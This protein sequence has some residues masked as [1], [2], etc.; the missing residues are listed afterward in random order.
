MKDIKQ[1]PEGRKPKLLE[2]AAKAPKTAMKDLW[3]KSKEK[4]ISELKET[5]SDEQTAESSNDPANSAAE[6]IVFAGKETAKKGAGLTYRGGK[7][8]AQTTAKKLK[9]HRLAS[10]TV[11]APEA[12]K[13][14]LPGKPKVKTIK[15]K[16][17][18]TIKT[19]KHAVKSSK[20]AVKTAKTSV[21]AAK[22]TAQAA[23][24]TAQRAVQ[25]ARAAAKAAAA[26]AKALAKAVVAAVKATVAIVKSLAALI[27]AGG[28]IVVVI[29]LVVALVAGILYSCYGIFFSG[30]NTG[31]GLTIQTAI[32]EINEEYTEKLDMIKTENQ[33]DTVEITGSR[34]GWPEILSVY[35]VKATTSQEVVTMDANKLEFLRA[36]FWDFHTISHKIEERKAAQIPDEDQEA[37]DP[38][39]ERVLLITVSHRTAEELADRYGF[40]PKQDRQLAELLKPENQSLWSA[41]LYGIGN[42]SG[43]LVMVALSQVGNAGGETYWSWYGFNSRVEWCACFVSWCGDQCG[44]IDAGV[45]PKFASCTFQGVPWFRER[46]LWQDNT[47]VPNPGDIIFFNWDGDG[48]VDHVGIVEKAE[49]GRVHTIEGNSGNACRQNS[50][51]LGYSRIY[52]YGILNY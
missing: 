46:G 43:D 22:K 36:V 7:K 26:S 20:T 18:K 24:K 3:L 52:G 16:T 27:A 48:L 50:Y 45:L 51:P 29:I 15:E 10:R 9:E 5:V 38:V 28:W 37:P 35:A 6:R 12:G 19:G 39:T 4:V 30:E 47:Y 32:T 40:T 8:L 1:K 21:Q 49:N 13:P 2:S 23:A 44:Y 34:A 42:G 31:T 33:H 14:P 41:A 25:A 17:K 11:K